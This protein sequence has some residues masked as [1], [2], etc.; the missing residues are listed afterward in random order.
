MS[1]YKNNLSA[2]EMGYIDAI[3][4]VPAYYSS[5]VTRGDSGEGRRLYYEGY[6][7]GKVERLRNLLLKGTK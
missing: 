6:A 4:G 3:N 7:R 5:M 1:W 2:D